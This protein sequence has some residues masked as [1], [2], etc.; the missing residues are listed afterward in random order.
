MPVRVLL[1][2]PS[3]G[4]V[5]AENVV[6]RPDL[7]GASAAAVAHAVR[8]VAPDVVITIEPDAVPD[9]PVVVPAGE[10]VT[11]ALIGAERACTDALPVPV[12]TA[13]GRSVTL[14]GAGVVNLIS[15]LFLVREG[16][17]VTVYD[18]APDPRADA[19]WTA[20]GCTRG[21]G[22]GRMFTLT[23]ADSYNSRSWNTDGTSNDLLARPISAHGWGVHART[24][25]P[26][27]ER[28][29]AEEFHGIPPWLADSYTED[30]FAMN[31]AADAGWAELR[32]TDPGLF[33]DGTGY[34]DG[35]LRLYTDEEYFRW[36]V[37]R[38]ERVGAV[39][40]VLTP[41][42]VRAGYPALAAACADGTIA[43]GLEVVGFTVNIHR[44]LAR[45]VTVLETEGVRFRWAEPVTGIRWSAPGVPD[46]LDTAAGTVRGDHY[47]LSPGAYG[48]RLL[49]GT[50]SHGRIQGMLGVW[51]T[52]PNVEPLLGHSVKIARKGHRAEETN[53][54]LGVDSAGAPIL[55][56]GS[57]YGWTGLDPDN[58]DQAELEVLF[59]ALEDTVRRFFPAAYAAAR[60]A[61]TLAASRQVCVRPWTSSCLGVFE[62][63]IT[64]DGGTLLVTGGHN[65]GG[66]A[67]SPVVAEAVLAALAGG[68]HPMHRRFH[69]ARLARFYALPA[70]ISRMIT[71]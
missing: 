57:G 36:H 60:D 22:D 68:S 1:I 63:M 18:R 54:T 67:Q 62:S 30:I 19:P 34:R 66:F 20:Y 26:A 37:A 41:S 33:D 64:A 28:R 45:L 71:S 39:R 25:L 47:V 12:A 38:N 35:I 58:V 52:V 46:G 65:T 53:V 11:Q 55:I 40:T 3:S 31:L 32:R 7:V 48:D 50:L 10:D 43:G 9:G 51:V 17:Q 2:H 61:G 14:V 15:A 5:A 21:G 42:Q 56:C 70:G 59:E 13:G 16:Y 23:E 44:F 29:W 4:G 8:N 27:A 24:G 49:R 6:H 69:P